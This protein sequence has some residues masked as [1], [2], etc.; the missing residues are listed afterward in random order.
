MAH[1]RT[2]LLTLLYSVLYK[3]QMTSAAF[4]ITADVTM[5]NYR[6]IC[7]PSESNVSED[8]GIVLMDC[9]YRSHPMRPWLLSDLI[10]WGRRLE[11]WSNTAARLAGWRSRCD[12]VRDGRAVP[13]A[14]SVPYRLPRQEQPSCLLMEFTD[15]VILQVYTAVRPVLRHTRKAWP[16]TIK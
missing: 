9:W 15:A 13:T 10:Q 14:I 11:G 5:A 12:F 16:G 8:T 1:R 6:F 3:D 4:W 2:K 7:R